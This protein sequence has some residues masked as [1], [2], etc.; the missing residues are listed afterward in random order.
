MSHL[1]FSMLAVLHAQD[2]HPVQE[3]RPCPCPLGILPS[4]AGLFYALFYIFNA[5]SYTLSFILRM[6]AGCFC[7]LRVVGISTYHLFC[8]LET[9]ACIF[10]IFPLV[11]SNGGSFI[12]VQFR[13]SET[14]TRLLESH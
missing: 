9:N 8:C 13:L 7:V 3:P 11:I 2:S 5:F 1:F 14:A 10:A 4:F 6:F 12:E